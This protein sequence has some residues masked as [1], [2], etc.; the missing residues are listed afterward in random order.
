MDVRPVRE[1]ELLWT[2]PEAW[3]RESNLARFMEA[4]GREGGP[5]PGDYDALW[6]WSVDRLEDFWESVWRFFG[7][8]ATRPYREVLEGREMPGARWFPGAELNY[9]EH[10]FRNRDPGRP[11]LLFRSETRPLTAVSW[12]EL[13]ARV[14]SVAAW[15]RAAGVG[16]GDRVVSY[17]P[18][19]PETMVAFLAAA[20]VGA[21]WSSC[22]PDFGTRSVI[23]RFRQIGPKVL[24]AVDGYAYGGRRFDRTREVAE[25]RRALPTLE[26]TVFVPCLD[27]A[28]SPPPGAVPWDEVA[29]ARAD[30]AFEPVPFDHPLW[31]VYSSGTTGL[32]KALVHG[33]GGIVVEHH[34]FL[35]LHTD[36]RPGD[37]FFWFSTTGWIMWNIL[38]GGLLVGAT[39]VLFDGSPGHP[40]LD[41]LWDLAG[42]TRATFFGAGAA[43]LVACM[44]A[45]LEPGRGR[46]LG[47]LR[48]VGSTGS[49][50]PPEGFRWVYDR[51]KPDVWLASVSGGT[52]VA[53]AFV[54]SSPPLPVHAGEI[55]C[56]CLGV[57]AEA[58][59]E[60]GRPLVDEVG[61]LVISEP[62]PS[63]PLYLWNDPDGRRYRESYFEMYPGRW[64]HGDWIRIT[65]RGSVVVLGRSDSTLKRMGVRMGSSE[66]YRVVEAL[67][68]VEESL[69]VGF[70]RR[71]GGYFMPLFVVLKE[72]LR[73][74]GE[75]EGR[76]RDRIRTALSPRH[77]PDAIYQIDAVPRTLNGKK[78]EVP[79]KKVLMGFPLDEAVNLDSMANPGSMA[80]FVD[81][82]KE[83]ARAG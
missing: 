56:R 40:S 11:A 67:P 36:L 46:D 29:G 18:N 54:G 33:H 5:D 52:D 44:N 23:D 43:F 50:L 42:D 57:K 82:A 69:V 62:M 20:S 9:A 17:L 47:A 12:Q 68:E 3:A 30:L 75:I 32:P 78:L 38:V 60:E 83:L 22:S 80:Y 39:P 51:V 2:P 55:Q 66:F 58:L 10:V 1:G 71:G 24:L 7:I 8:R 79:V 41:T 76:I 59:D 19:I 35:G 61:E 45:G 48:C 15:L 26:A 21:V 14:A 74:D 77:L 70:D 63:M 13:E 25:I 28:A 73:L 31:V 16:P 72:G 49:P 81:L 4:V 64:R 6:R 65:P 37:R 27:P 34:K 53:T